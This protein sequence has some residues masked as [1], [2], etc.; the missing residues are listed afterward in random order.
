[1]LKRLKRL[2]VN[3]YN[4]QN[5]IKWDVNTFIKLYNEGK[6]L[7]EISEI[8]I[9]SVS[10]VSLALKKI[11]FKVNNKQNETKFNEN[12]FNVID[13]EEKAYWLGF[14]Y[15]DGYV[16]YDRNTF[17]LSLSLKDI[18]HLK[19]FADFMG[20]SDNVKTD[21]YRCRF[22]VSNKHLKA[23]LIELGVIPRK[24]LTLTFPTSEQVPNNLIHHFIR[25]YFDGDGTIITKE[26][27]CVKLRIS[28]LGTESFLKSVLYA[29]DIEKKVYKTKSKVMYFALAV[30]N[31]TKFCEY[32]Y[33][34]C[35]I[36]LLRKKY[37]YERLPS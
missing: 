23:R 36:T 26:T 34:D 11:K 10:T 16:S 4:K 19:R 33:K 35:T 9:V 13:N 37:L 22:Y 20:Y 18:E 8:C 17:E 12:I 1:V 6:T 29:V 24:S 21:D 2:G 27:S 3:V 5:V 7:T 31:S 14:I 25:G 15:A 28:L 32:I 30:K